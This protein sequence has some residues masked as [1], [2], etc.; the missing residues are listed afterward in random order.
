MNKTR[1]DANPCMLA[2]YSVAIQS[3]IHRMCMREKNTLHVSGDSYI[4]YSLDESQSSET[5]QSFD[6]FTPVFDQDYV[7]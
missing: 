3:V 2:S 5:L 7:H 4:P 1:R 6:G